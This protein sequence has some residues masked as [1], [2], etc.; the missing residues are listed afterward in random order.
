MGALKNIK[1][2]MINCKSVSEC[3]A[4]SFMENFILGT[5]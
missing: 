1:L 5:V 3:T 4:L 2:Y